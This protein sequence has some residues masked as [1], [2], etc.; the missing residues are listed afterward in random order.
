MSKQI[1]TIEKYRFDTYVGEENNET[2]EVAGELLSK[3]EYDINGNIILSITYDSNGNISEHLVFSFNAAHLLEEELIFDDEEIVEKRRFDYDNNGKI[4]NEKIY[5]QDNSFDTLFYTYNASDQLI[6]KRLV[7]A[8]DETESL[9]IFEYHKD[10]ISNECE[11]D[12]NNELIYQ[13]TY[14][15]DDNDNLIKYS[16]FDALDDKTIQ[17]IYE[18]DENKNRIKT[19]NYD[20]TG[21]LTT[22]S[23][24][25]FNEH[26][27]I[28]MLIED[29]TLV[30]SKY[31]F[32]YDS[33]GN[34][35]TQKEF[36]EDD[37][38]I[39]T[40]TFE[41]DDNQLIKT[42][43]EGEGFSH[44]FIIENEITYFQ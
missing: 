30:S 2:I 42:I 32:E 8:D 18:Y 19:L 41:Y 10:K 38:L 25:K 16:H 21:K 27:Q 29:T 28:I 14:I 26:K 34:I 15:Y 20:N 43:S 31:Q 36:T 4:I 33:N 44:N 1:K 6:E 9:L 13:K 35:I 22:R 40:L 37:E 12:Y 17:T 39:A 23:S 7:N 11:F 24:Y 3:T 5:Y